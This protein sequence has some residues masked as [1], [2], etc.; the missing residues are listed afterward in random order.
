MFWLC[1]IT[2]PGTPANENPVTSYGQVV[3]T[4]RQ[5][6]PTWDQMEGIWIDRCG[7]FA[8][9]GIP[10]AVRDPE[11]AH[12]LDPI[13]AP[14]GPSSASR[15]EKRAWTVAR[16]RSGRLA[17]VNGAADGVPISGTITGWSDG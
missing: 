16:S 8:S 14:E 13:P 3:L 2:T 10:E 1:P 5:C 12:E 4:G 11:T 7:S 15:L 17:V 6:S 9:S